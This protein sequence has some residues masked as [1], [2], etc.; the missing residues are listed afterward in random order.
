MT[1]DRP[2]NDPTGPDRENAA[3]AA[4]LRPLLTLSDVYGPGLIYN[5]YVHP[6]AC[7]WLPSDPL[8]RD[9]VGAAQIC[10]A[11][12]MPTLCHRAAVLPE[13]LALF[14]DAGAELRADIDTYHD[15]ASYL[16]Q[17]GKLSGLGWRFVH[18]F[19]QPAAEIARATGWVDGDLVSRLNNKCGLDKLVPPNHVPRRLLTPPEDLRADS[20]PCVV[21]ACS[22]QS[23][24]GG[25]DVRVC[26]G[27]EDVAEA[28]RYFRDCD[29]AVVEEWL[30]I[31]ENLCLNYA[32]LGLS[33]VRYLGV[34][35]QIV[36]EQ[37]GF[38]GNRIAVGTEASALA[39][40]VTEEIARSA[41]ALGYRGIAGL[42]VAVLRDGQVRVLD[43]NFRLN[44]STRALLLREAIAAR[45]GATLL[46]A[47]SFKMAAPFATL[48]SVARAAL[49]RGELVPLSVF[50]AE[51]A[52]YPAGTENRLSG[53]VPGR[54]R[55]EIEERL[56]RLSRSGLHLM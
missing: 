54:D 25:V 14:R 24:G 21:K 27:P 4:G 51:A 3:S 46:H 26:H 10:I 37:G 55:D 31:A 50:S 5:G 16:D 15:H 30:D 12:D 45:F 13:T 6:Q 23:S 1:A 11:G 22:D 35:E 18:Q 48:L 44:A 34:A 36:D 53:I 40:R 49:E 17:V 52:G 42:D 29:R 33:D 38:H 19:V 28:R 41:A 20:F 47:A 56:G 39:R 32:I 43:L 8:V 7:R 9:G 2:R